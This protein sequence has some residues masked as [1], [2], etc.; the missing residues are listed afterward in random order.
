MRIL[1]LILN[2]QKLIKFEFPLLFK[3]IDQILYFSIIIPI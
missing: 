1:C 3:L 2:D